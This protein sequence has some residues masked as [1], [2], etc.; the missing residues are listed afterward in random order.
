M[1]V[2]CSN[3][4]A[5]LPCDDDETRADEPCGGARFRV[6]FDSSPL[7][8]DT[9]AASDIAGMQLAAD[10]M[11]R[12]RRPEEVVVPV[13]Q[14]LLRTTVGQLTQELLRRVERK[15]AE[16]R[17]AASVSAY[18]VRQVDDIKIMDLPS[19]E[20]RPAALPECESVSWG[21]DVGES[22]LYWRIDACMNANDTLDNFFTPSRPGEMASYD[23]I[24][25]WG[26]GPA[27]GSAPSSARD[28]PK[29][30]AAPGPAAAELRLGDC[31]RL[32][33]ARRA[34]A[35]EQR[36]F[37]PPA[38]TIA[39][40]QRC[41]YL[42]I[43]QLR[44]SRREEDRANSYF[45]IMRERMGES[46]ADDPSD[47]PDGGVVTRR[48]EAN[49]TARRAL[50][51]EEAKARSR[52]AFDEERF[53][54]YIDETAFDAMKHLLTLATLAGNFVENGQW[55]RL[56][57]RHM[58][59]PFDTLPLADLPTRDEQEK[60]YANSANTAVLAYQFK[61]GDEELKARRKAEAEARDRLAYQAQ[62]GFRDELLD[63]VLDEMG[64]DKEARREGLRA[65]WYTE[66]GASE[67]PPPTPPPPPTPKTPTTEQLD[68][69]YEEM[70][71]VYLDFRHEIVALER[72]EFRELLTLMRRVLFQQAQA[73]TAAVRLAYAE[74]LQATSALEL[75]A[76]VAYDAQSLEDE[77]AYV[78]PWVLAAQ[79][80]EREEKDRERRA[81]EGA[82][83]HAAAETEAISVV[84]PE[85]EEEFRARLAAE[86]HNPFRGSPD[87]ELACP[88]A[89]SAMNKVDGRAG[90]VLEGRLGIRRMPFVE[91]HKR[92]V[93]RGEEDGAF[94]AILALAAAA[95]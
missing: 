56:I 91:A 25:E 94:Q 15:Y 51:E 90:E 82:Q 71:D 49:H 70:L 88:V 84:R 40:T 20:E 80:K 74:E 24:V 38:P 65:E 27:P 32:S 45:R 87:L 66:Q 47:T 12:L 63:V 64:K 17:A 19:L 89:K 21:G 46:A 9:P 1:L 73:D 93:L 28:T 85:T 42:D 79:R 67:V 62:R 36:L 86:R 6:L 13:R 10:P 30:R 54:K 16:V 55:L 33:E 77:M 3:A 43:L 95:E 76:Y 26:S 39:V 14:P 22:V 11:R 23:L 34:A 48:T 29:Q 37:F 60:R 7:R 72:K 92:E 41:S 52:I 2:Q 57:R 61:T 35:E 44:R 53:R 58:R 8:K 78:E 5:P 50:A 18:L 59:Y 81:E 83:R 68:H 31:I 4:L 69:R 75:D